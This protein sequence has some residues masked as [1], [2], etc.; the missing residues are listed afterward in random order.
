MS[1]SLILG[2]T[3]AFGFANLTKGTRRSPKF[4]CS[5]LLPRRDMDG[6]DHCFLGK[7]CPNPHPPTPGLLS[8]PPKSYGLAMQYLDAYQNDPEKDQD[9]SSKHR[10]SHPCSFQGDRSY[11]AS[12]LQSACGPNNTQNFYS[13]TRATRAAFGKYMCRTAPALS[14]ATSP[15]AISALNSSTSI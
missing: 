10:R 4:P 9:N 2:T 8:L 13:R 14:I 12:D 11:E 3:H 5:I 1:S 15:E 6:Y 7:S